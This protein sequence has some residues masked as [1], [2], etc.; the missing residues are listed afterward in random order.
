MNLKTIQISL[1]IGI[2]GGLGLGHYLFTSGTKED[3][4]FEELLGT[5][6]EK[7]I[8][9]DKIL[10]LK[11]EY[12][13]EVALL[14][15]VQER[16]TKLQIKINEKA[17]LLASISSEVKGKVVTGRVVRLNGEDSPEVCQITDNDKL[18]LFSFSIKSDFAVLKDSETGRE[19]AVSSTYY[20][21][22]PKVNSS[23]AGKPYKL[24]TTEGVFKTDPTVVLTEKTKWILIPQSVYFGLN[25]NQDL[26]LSTPLAG[27]GRD[28]GDL[29]WRVLGLGITYNKADKLRGLINIF[30]VRLLPKTF[31]NSF[32]GL[33]IDSNKK[34]SIS[35]SVGL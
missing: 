23:W 35:F 8:L 15:E 10:Q 30:S 5:T 1:I 31:S 17:E 22:D 28:K 6:E 29:D 27:L 34:T 21:L 2:L 32:Y 4:K 11:T 24:D 16:F 33:D 3:K 7:K 12:I 20:L 13:R 19:R 25:T 26:T 18:E 9:E 14:Q